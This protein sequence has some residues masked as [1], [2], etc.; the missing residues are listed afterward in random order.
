MLTSS[1]VPIS[2]YT[3]RIHCGCKTPH[4]VL[5]PHYSSPQQAWHVFSLSA[6]SESGMMI[7]TWTASPHTF[8]M[9][10]SPPHH[11]GRNILRWV[12]PSH[13]VMHSTTTELAGLAMPGKLPQH[14]CL[15][16]LVLETMF[17]R[18]ISLV[19]SGLAILHSD[20]GRTVPLHSKISNSNIADAFL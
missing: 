6:S 20:L 8:T 4:Q 13:R 16:A 1:F 7:N 12:I 3:T 11:F 14:S 10:Q 2:C 5:Y 18:E 17:C 15:L 19:P 9:Y